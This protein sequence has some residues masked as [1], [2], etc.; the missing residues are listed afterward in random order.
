MAGNGSAVKDKDVQSL[1]SMSSSSPSSRLPVS[2]LLYVGPICGVS[3]KRKVANGHV[4]SE[5]QAEASAV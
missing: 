3:R 2:A 4:C 5:R 1:P